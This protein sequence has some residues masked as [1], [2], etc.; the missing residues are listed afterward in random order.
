MEIAVDGA[1][2]DLW[3]SYLAAEEEEKEEE[4]RKE[5][6]SIKAKSFYTSSSCTT[7]TNAYSLKF[8]KPN[9]IFPILFHIII[10]KIFN[11]KIIYCLCH[12]F[13]YWKK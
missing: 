3:D 5:K 13:E 4:M 12:I 10:V 8:I 9:R 6:L 2:G 7:L 11:F 1:D